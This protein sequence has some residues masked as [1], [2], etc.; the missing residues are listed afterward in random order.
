MLASR[1]ITAAAALILSVA[2][3]PTPSHAQASREGPTFAASGAWPGTSLQRPDIAYDPVNDV[4]LVVS[5]PMTHGRFQTA[6]G[7]PLG[8]NEF[9]IPNA[10]AYNQTPRV[11]YG[12]GDVPGH[13]ARRPQRS[14]REHRLGLWPP[15]VGS[16][17]AARR[18]SSDPIS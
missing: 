6:D 9:Y 18:R 13:L 2:A 7:V 3:L 4:Y 16:A 17:P 14:D 10:A 15:A 11:A 12:D 8:A 1:F 5:G